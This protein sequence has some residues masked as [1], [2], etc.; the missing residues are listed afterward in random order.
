[1][2]RPVWR[3]GAFLGGLLRAQQRAIADAGDF[4]RARLARNMNADAGRLAVLLGVPLGRNGDQF[5]VAVAFGDV[6]EH[7]G[8]QGAG[9]VQLLAPPLDHALVGQVAQHVA[10]GSAVVVLQA[11][12]ARD[13]AHAGLALVRADEGDNVF[14]GGKAGGPGFLGGFLQD[15]GK[16]GPGRRN[17]Q[18]GFIRRPACDFLAFGRPFSSALRPF[19]PRRRAWRRGR[20]PPCAGPCGAARA[21]RRSSRRALRS[22]RQPG[23]G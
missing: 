9:V 21:W 20:R 1:M 13:L 23:R 22:G 14:A 12:G 2:T 18:P 19:W 8:G 3:I 6:G 15:D 7:D 10:Q 17:R 16:V 11:E 5:A 4:V